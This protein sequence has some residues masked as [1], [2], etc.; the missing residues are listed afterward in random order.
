MRPVLTIA[1]F[2]AAALWFFLA[3]TVQA[4]S[5]GPQ[6]PPVT[7]NDQVVTAAGEAPVAQAPALTRADVEAW[8]D[9]F[10]SYALPKTD[11]AGA[12][13][14]VVKDGAVLLQKGYGYADVEA[15]KP[16]DPELT[17]FRP[18]SVSKL[19]TWTA[20]MQQVEAGKLDLDADV[21][22]YLDFQI[23]PR[24][25]KPITLRNILTHTPG[26]EE[27]VKGIITRLDGGVPALGEHLKRWVPER[28]YEPGRTPA[29]SNYATALAGYIVARASGMSFD[30]YMDRQVFAP[31]GMQHSSFRQPLPEHLEPLMSKGYA[32]ASQP[33]KPY[34]VVGPAP[35]GSLAASGADMARFMIAH[36]N[37]GEIDGKRI[38]S[39]DTAK[40][41]HTTALTILPRLNRMELGFYETNYNGQRVIAHGGD[42]Q[43][44]HSYL[45]LFLDENVGLFVS[46]NSTGKEG[47]SGGLRGSLFEQFA[48]R[49]FPAPPA[50]G[51]VDDATAK[52]H[53]RMM[54]GLYDNSRRSQ[55]SF[56]S[57]LNLFGQ[58]KVYP[59]EDGTISVSIV[60]DL[61]GEP[62]RWR[63]I[64]PFVWRDTAGKQLLAAEVQDGRVTRW[65]WDDVSPF[66]VFEPTPAA[67]SAAW[68][69][70]AFVGGVVA[71]LLTVLAW[72]VSALVRRRYG[73]SYSLQGQDAQWHRRMR[74]AS[75]LSVLLWVGW[76]VTITRL[77]SDLSRLSPSADGWLWFLQLASLLI[78]IGAA[79]VGVWNAW[80]VLRSQRRWYAKVWA[81]VLALAVVVGLWVALAHNLIAFDVNY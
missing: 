15:R 66:M 31:L 63:E 58:T 10:M 45:H 22:Q 75:L 36:L 28:I 30:D 4:Q 27:Q 72:P 48:D 2:V 3:L 38:L 8:L 13:V 79:I 46:F 5:S 21:N 53:G 76:G 49:Y 37:D 77:M 16:V 17:L 69:V 67:R 42:T 14:V 7:P 52:E 18:G 19:F 33:A 64:E 12:V 26:F 47:A 51:S 73:V 55:S 43:W 65:S 1:A 9:G 41:M 44:F 34:E 50:G 56:L 54:A 57:L 70:P 20:V 62:V 61:A 39:A 81:I 60:R 40:Q 80:I 23:P 25:G 59:N 71:M 35:A 6:I 29:Y 32:V 68:L 11:V 24:E 74:V 78:F